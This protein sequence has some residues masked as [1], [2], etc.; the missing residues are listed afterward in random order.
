[1]SEWRPIKTFRRPDY[2][3]VDLWLSVHASPRSFG[4]GDAWR[5]VDCY[6]KGGKWFHRVDGK[7]MEIV[8][9]YITHW[10]PQPN[11]PRRTAAKTGA[12]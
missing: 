10:M 2:R 12:E 1:M 7:E 11:P 4:M 8:A 6:R 5:V 3:E 9:D